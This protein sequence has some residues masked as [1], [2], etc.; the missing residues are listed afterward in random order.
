MEFQSRAEVEY[1][2]RAGAKLEAGRAFFLNEFWLYL[3]PDDT[4][5]TPH[6]QDGFW[7]SWITKWVSQQFKDHTMFWDIGANVGYYSMFAAANGLI[8]MAFEP[9]QDLCDYINLSA[10]ANKFDTPVIVLPRAL[11]D[12]AGEIN[13]MKP[14][15]H[16]GAAYISEQT[17]APDEAHKWVSETVMTKT[18]DGLFPNALPGSHLMKMDAEGAEPK[19]WEGM[20]GF[21]RRNSVTIF[22]EWQPDRYDDAAGFADKLLEFDVSLIDY[23]GNERPVTKE[24][25]LSATDWI[26]IVVRN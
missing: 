23:A 13:L 9:Q 20:Q 1:V 4:A 26:T 8:V 10:M 17:D 2:G 15:G 5:F 18:L 22:M 6:W 11:S 3:E 7:E 16:S 19:I 24:E 12:R 25:L 21:L 14:E